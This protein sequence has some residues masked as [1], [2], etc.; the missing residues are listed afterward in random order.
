MYNT[1]MSVLFHDKVSKAQ[2]EVSTHIKLEDPRLTSFDGK[3]ECTKQ[4]PT[5]LAKFVC[6]KRKHR[7]ADKFTCRDGCPQPCLVGQ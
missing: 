1:F 7:Y 6:R 3:T 2:I 4:T 5:Y